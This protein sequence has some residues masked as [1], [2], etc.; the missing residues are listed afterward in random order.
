MRG[1]EE[2][3]GGEAT[4]NKN[5]LRRIASLQLQGKDGHDQDLLAIVA[6]DPDTLAKWS[7]PLT[8]EEREARDNAIFDH[9]LAGETESEVANNAKLNVGQVCRILHV[10]RASK[11]D[12]IQITEQ[13]PTYNVWNFA[14]CDPR[15]GGKYGDLKLKDHPGR[16]PGQAVLNLVLWLTEPFDLVVDP[17][18]GGG[19]TIDVCKY[20]LRRYQCFDIEPRR[21]D[22]G[23]HDIRQGYP[24]LPC[25]PKFILLD[26]P[27]WRLKREKYSEDGVASLSYL[28]WKGFM[29]K[30]AIDTYKTLSKG[31]TVALFIQSFLDEW[32]SGEYIFANYDCLNLFRDAKFKAIMEISVNMTSQNKDFRDVLWA[33]KNQKLLSIKR[34]VL[35]F[36]KPK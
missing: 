25:K 32:E 15:F 1:G 27:Y 23:R 16:I 3:V 22:I 31:G 13:P 29:K 9:W 24:K 5:V 30:L 8:K 2:K 6:N 34:D 26:P 18:G 17:M 14:T 12:T 36:Q 10:L 35:V 7:M 21:P 11:C 4:L 19:T 20:A 28:E 33:K